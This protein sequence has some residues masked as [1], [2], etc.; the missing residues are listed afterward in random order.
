M[1]PPGTCVFGPVYA[2]EPRTV[3][4]YSNNIF[5]LN[6]KL[7]LGKG[8]DPFSGPPTGKG[9]TIDRPADLPRMRRLSKHL[10][11]YYALDINTRR[12]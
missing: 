5:Q 9:R 11:R 4:E 8:A 12:Q 3:A 6:I 7:G 1:H 2:V 10:K